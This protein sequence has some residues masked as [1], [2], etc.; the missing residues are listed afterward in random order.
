MTDRSRRSRSTL[1]SSFWWLNRQLVQIVQKQ[2][3]WL[4]SMAPEGTAAVWVLKM[5]NLTLDP[6][7]P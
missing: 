3:L 6:C 4:M 2:G 7:A 1:P 5:E